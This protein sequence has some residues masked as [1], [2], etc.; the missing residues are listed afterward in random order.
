MRSCRAAMGSW[1]ISIDWI[2]RGARICFWPSICRGDRSMPIFMISTPNRPSAIAATQKARLPSSASASICAFAISSDEPEGKPRASLCNRDPRSRQQ[3]CREQ[4]RPV[5][6][7]GW[8]GCQDD[9][10]D[11]ARLN[12]LPQRRQTSVDRA[13]HY[14]AAPAGRRARGSGRDNCPPA[15]RYSDRAA[16]RRRKSSSGRGADRCTLGTDRRPSD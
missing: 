14:R 1:R 9:L 12:T 10:L 13:R 3:V 15:R 16:S 2:M 4:R 6:F 5:A 8:T 11:P 7:H